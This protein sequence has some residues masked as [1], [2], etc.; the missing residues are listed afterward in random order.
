VTNFS[1]KLFQEVLRLEDIADRE[2]KSLYKLLSDF[3]FSTSQMIEDSIHFP[4]PSSNRG[5][6][7]GRKGVPDQPLSVSVLP[8][9]RV[10][11]GAR[12]L[13]QITELLDIKLADI[14]DEYEVRH[15]RN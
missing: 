6:T 10:C 5:Q 14:V 3:L 13:L 4:P 11:V 7:R 9:L 2:S 8:L 1:T 12:K 15:Q